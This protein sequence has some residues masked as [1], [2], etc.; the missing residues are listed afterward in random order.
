MPPLD[1]KK[2]SVDERIALAKSR[3]E[4]L[5]DHARA[6]I[7]LRESNN[8]VVYSPLLSSQVGRS[9]AAHAFNSFQ[10]SM[11]SFEVIRLCALWDKSDRDTVSIPTVAELINS[12]EVLEALSDEC[13]SHWANMSVNLFNEHENLDERVIIEEIFRKEQEKR[14]REETKQTLDNLMEALTKVIT[15]S[16]SAELNAVINWRNKHLAHSLVQTIAESNAV[17]PIPNAK[18]GEEVALLDHSIEIIDAF[19]KGINGKSFVWDSARKHSRRNA[20]ALWE[21]CTFR[22]KE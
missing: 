5:V 7:M 8:L 2:K 19:H 3:T 14:A 16:A 20:A 15:I 22:V 1:A 12:S 4:A 13:Y 17:I 21:G 10:Q 9:Y 18:Y 6:Q 11:H